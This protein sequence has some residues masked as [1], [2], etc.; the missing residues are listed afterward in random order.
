MT[1]T[2]RCNHVMSLP[3][4]A[5]AAPRCGVCGET[6]VSR[7]AVRPPVFTGHCRGPHATFAPLD[8]IPVTLRK[9][10]EHG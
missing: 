7:V 6:V 5:S 8:P 10:P 4:T 2:F 9:E 3:D 1:I